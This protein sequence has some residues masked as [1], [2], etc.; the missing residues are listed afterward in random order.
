MS[1]FP[2]LLTLREIQN[3]SSV[4]P[5]I[6]VQ[7]EDTALDKVL[8]YQ[9]LSEFYCESGLNECQTT[10]ECTATNWGS[11]YKY[12][13]KCND[14]TLDGVTLTP[15]D[16][17]IRPSG[18]CTYAVPRW[19]S[20]QEVTLNIQNIDVNVFTYDGKP[21]LYL[22]ISNEYYYERDYSFSQAISQVF[23]TIFTT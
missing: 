17:L 1:K 8:D 16:E 11:R 21:T 9:E 2:T 4:N 18:T 22:Y 20:D 7:Y 5:C 15:K 23:K 12:S 19:P 14:Y 10:S 3:E 6:S 13:C